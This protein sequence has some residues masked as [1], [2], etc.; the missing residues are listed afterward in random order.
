MFTTQLYIQ[1]REELKSK[2]EN[3]LILF[4]GNEESPMNYADNPY[5]FRQHSS[6][7]YYFGIDRPSVVAIIDLDNGTETIFGDELNIDEIVW[8]GNQTSLKEEAEKVGIYDVLPTVKLYTILREAIAS[9]RNIHFL[10]PY[11]PENKIKL[12]RLL[13]IRPDQFALKSSD[14][15][16]KAVISQREIKD[17]D[18]IIE[19]EKAVNWSVDMHVS[20]I[21]YARPGMKESE[22]SAKATQVVLEKQGQPSFP[23]IATIRG[24]I[25]HNHYHGNTLKKGQLFLLDAGAETTSRYAGDLTS[26]FP[27]SRS[28]S[29][30][31]K[32]IY[33]LVLDAHYATAKMLKPGIEF[34]DVH[35]EAARIIFNGLKELGLTKGN[36]EAAISEGAHALFFPTGLGH[37]M[38]LDVHDMEDLGEL[39][40]GYKPGEAKSSQFG[41]K[42]LRLAKELIPGH[43]LTI[44]PG[45]Y[46]IPELIKLWRTEK[47]FEQFIN[48]KNLKSY[49]NFGGVRIEQDYLITKRSSRLLGRKKPMEI[50]E[51]EELRQY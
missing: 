27:V 49:M 41:L 5:P 38:G 8:M 21:K 31:Q 26:T 39:N 24:E 10:P 13:N 6:F 32:E 35:M 34:R 42:S 25:L 47:K 2:M 17:K 43:V 12:L 11:R 33:Q 45:I 44:E 48:Y 50:D 15:L 46:F 40:V 22:V 37:M 23:I 28:F 4:L 20:A 51:I 14:K 29:R 7:L 3:G 36:T 9:G 30:K 1:R 18:E 16:V 19:I